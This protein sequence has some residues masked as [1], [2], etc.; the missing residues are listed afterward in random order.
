L[1]I[2]ILGTGYVG[3]EIASSLSKNHIVTCIDHGN[4]FSDFSGK[5]ENI[6]LVKGEI[7]NKNLIKEFSK[8]VDLICY[9]INT[10]GVVDCMENSEL[11]K[12]INIDDFQ[13]LLESIENKNCHFL[14]LST[15]FVY[16]DAKKNYE[17][18]VTK[19]LTLYGKFRL[20]QESL[21]TKSNFPYTILRIANIYGHQN[22][23]VSKFNNAI[24][25]FISNIFSN[26]EIS[27]YGDGTQLVDFVH[28][29][30]FLKILNQIIDDK[31]ENEIYNISNEF[32][33]SISD[34]V[35]DMK[36][37]AE[38]KYNI[39]VQLNKRDDDPLP[40]IPNTSTSKIQKKFLWKNS[41]NMNLKLESMFE[42]IKNS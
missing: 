24:D 9:C 12:K 36:N 26:Q 28:I 15:S 13:E 11:Y 42:N 39:S 41:Q 18:S 8:D 34:I 40:N 2:L 22:F 10:G 21:L 16:S 37:I 17:D 20:E 19:P 6:K 33:M 27:L 14:L 7:Q 31:S 32:R 35:N 4:N 30:N 38:T 29:D 23:C 3:S 5:L 25:K 1:K